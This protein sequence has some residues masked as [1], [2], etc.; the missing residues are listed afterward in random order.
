MTWG[1]KRKLAALCA[2]GKPRVLDLFAGCGGLSLGFQAAGF[3]I[4]AAVENDPDAARS[5][6]TN[7]HTGKPDHSKARDICSPP[8]RL[9]TQLGLGDVDQVFDVIVG[10]PPC[11]A[12]ARV[13]RPKLREIEDHPTAFLHDPRARLYVDWLHYVDMCKPL[14]VLMENVPDALNHGGQNIAE[15]TC[16]VLEGKGYICGYT[17]LNAAYYGVPQMRERLFLIGYRR[18]IAT[19][20]TFPEPTH[21]VDLPSGYD[22]SRAVALKL[23]TGTRA[24]EMASDYISP[25]DASDHLPP[26]PTAIEAIG[27]LP[28]IDAQAQLRSGALKRGARRFDKPIPWDLHAQGV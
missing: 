3:E 22:G 12:F 21:W 2:G 11:Q 24:P 19:D 7:F 18:E 8:E 6:G 5:H 25:P 10:G 23:L 4:A 16:E 1:I 28:S 14:A 26:T 13:G 27:D 9:V 17:L 15:E 20:V